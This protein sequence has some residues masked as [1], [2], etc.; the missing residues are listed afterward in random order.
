M[1]KKAQI[2]ENVVAADSVIV[3]T[4]ALRLIQQNNSN[5]GRRAQT[6]VKCDK[7]KFSNLGNET[8]LKLGNESSYN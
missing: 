5:K 1:Y 8:E 2:I 3:A 7:R 4:K 6:D